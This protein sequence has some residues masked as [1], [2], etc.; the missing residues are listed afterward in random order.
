MPR[1]RKKGSKDKVKR[2]RRTKKQ[3]GKDTV[4]NANVVN[5]VVEAL[6]EEAVEE[7]NEEELVD[8]DEYN[9]NTEEDEE[10]EDE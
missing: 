5:G 8:E 2:T 6:P 7:P 9:D 3:I 1:G 10:N 4:D